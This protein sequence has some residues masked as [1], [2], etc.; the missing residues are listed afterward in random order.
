MIALSDR[1]GYLDEPFESDDAA[2]EV[3]EWI[4]DLLAEL[5]AADS[6]PT[7]AL[8]GIDLSDIRRMA[9]ALI[10][11]PPPPGTEVKWKMLRDP[12]Q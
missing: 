11:P 7:E 1:H 3:V 5:D 2:G 8:E 4:E 9:E 6:I 10:P 12:R